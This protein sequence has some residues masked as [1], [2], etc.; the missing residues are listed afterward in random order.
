MNTVSREAAKAQLLHPL[1]LGPEPHPPGLWARLLRSPQ[2]TSARHDI[3]SRINADGPAA[4]TQRDLELI[5]RKRHLDGKAAHQLLVGVYR[6]VLEAFLS[7]DVLS[8]QEVSYLFDLRHA[9]N[10]GEDDILALERSVIHPRFNKA[11]EDVIHDRTVTTGERTLL[12]QLG[13]S[14]RLS[15]AI[16]TDL[17]RKAA[18]ELLQE[19]LDASIADHRLSPTEDADLKALA[20]NLGISMQYDQATKAEL[21]RFALLWRIENGDLP[22]VSV[23]LNWQKGETCHF[24]AP[25]RWLEFRK[26]TRTV[27]YAGQGVSIRIARGLYY[28]VGR[29][30]P[31]RVTEQGLAEIDKG[32]LY[33]TN[34]RLFFDGQGKNTSI[35]LQNIIAFE[36]YSDG[37]AIEKGSGRTPHLMIDGD[38]EL[39]ATIL[40]RLLVAP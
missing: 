14:L 32:T 33:L 22:E 10:L 20:A 31:Q 25:V 27:G 35:R 9:F 7:D 16:Q 11:I 38:V 21:A 37:I 5:L 26:T 2:P 8:D 29:S 24:A 34:K 3:V 13:S 36:V 23:D 39:A 19:T 17:F 12:A 40:G 1:T 4:V 18:T 6:A 30:T 15:P 28:R